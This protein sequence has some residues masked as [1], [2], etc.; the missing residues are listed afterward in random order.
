MSKLGLALGGGGARGFAHIGLLKVI[1]AEGIKVHSITG[2]SMG[3]VVG[4]LY[5]YFRNAEKV[6][7]FLLDI[8]TKTEFIKEEMRKLKNNS[9]NENHNYFEQFFKYIEKRLQVLKSLNHLSYF[10]EKITNEIFEMLP[11]VNIEDFEINFSAVATDLLTGK[12]INFTEGKFRDIAKASSAIPG[13]F[14]PVDYKGYFL[15]DGSASDITPAGI[16]KQLGSDRTIAVNVMRDLNTIEKPEN[17]LNILYRT[18]DITSYHLSQLRLKEADLIIRPP[19][20]AINW[21]DFGRAEEIINSGEKETRKY[22]QQIKKL[23]RRN[24]YL[25]KF[26][27]FLKEIR[28][29]E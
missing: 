5:A 29:K 8:L 15:V 24:S 3:A 20:S 22:L 11:D 10:D 13:I 18:E 19:L 12:R 6:E 27:K 28:E 21:T 7:E 9:E 1:D 16:V 17:V 26:D 14:P 25:L 4:G 2:C 23:T